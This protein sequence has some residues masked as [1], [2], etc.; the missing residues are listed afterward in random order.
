MMRRIIAVAGVVVLALL[1]VAPSAHA[2][3][4][5]SSGSW[6]GSALDAGPGTV[7]VGSYDLLG[8]FRRE[9]LNREVEVTVSASPAGSG[10]C[11]VAPTTLPKATTP[12]G[13][14]A[15][16]TIPCNG[17]YTLTATATTTDNNVFFTSE[18][19]TLDREVAVAAP[20]PTVTGIEASATSA[21][22]TIA[23]IW[24]D[25]LPLAPDLT[26]YVIERKINDGDFEPLDTVAFDQLTYDDSD[27]PTAKGQATYRVFAVRPAPTGDEIS[28][29]SEE[30][31]TPF[32]AAPRK[33]A[34]GN[35]SDGSGGS[36]SGGSDGS[37]SSTDG[38]QT[39]TGRG[40][41]TGG[42]AAVLPPR[43][44]SGT[45]L[46]PLLRPASEA[47]PEPDP[48]FK[49]SLPYKLAKP[50]KADRTASNDALAS[51]STDAQQGRGMVIPVATA[52]VLAIWA[53]H[54]RMLA[55]AARPLD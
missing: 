16:L 24:H 6:N 8:T 40:T 26:G 50:G 32:A 19:A 22:R 36:G 34:G 1:T 31:E 11:A 41:S 3:E 9:S 39:G 21:G 43:V 44:F 13:F 54:L 23:L 35:G 20:A 18:T 12:R 37:G 46:P 45:F 48:G 29:A 14:S 51:I 28:P 38:S 25:M 33:P 42:R 4:S 27:L 17:I 15:A 47:I 7:T 49:E 55:R 10:P 52:L 53:V 2:D 5:I 30:V